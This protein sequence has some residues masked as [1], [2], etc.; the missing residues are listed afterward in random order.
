M[1]DY[2]KRVS[3]AEVLR[4]AAN[5]IE[6]YIRVEEQKMAQAT[7]RIAALDESRARLLR[8]AD[9]YEKW[10]PKEAWA[11]GNLDDG[12][13]VHKDSY[14]RGVRDGQRTF[15]NCDFDPSFSG[16]LCD[17]CGRP[18]AP[19]SVTHDEAKQVLASGDNRVPSD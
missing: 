4:Q 13:P 7:A 14:R 12:T 9:S 2:G 8:D 10:Q 17:N 16:G 3:A 5:D 1:T 15:C 18:E 6:F 11:D 19:E